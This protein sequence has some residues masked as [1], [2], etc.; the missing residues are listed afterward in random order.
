M[1]ILEFYC[2]QNHRIYQFLARTQAQAQLTPLCPDNP[3]Y[4]LQRRPSAFAIVG[5]AKESEEQDGRD[6]FAHL[7]EWALDSLMQDMESQFGDEDQADPDPRQLG[8]F[9]GRLT[10]MMGDKAPPHL[11]EIVRRLQAGEDPEKIEE[12]FGG[13][14]AGD[15]S[16]NE[17]F[18]E[19]KT[20][21]RA[22]R[23]P[24]RDPKL[25]DLREHLPPEANT[26]P[27]S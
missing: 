2:P 22:H 5:K 20:L 25:Y 17:L 15:E 1:P 10:S 19:V 16:V 26:A 18:S 9:M 12:Q 13:P 23:A 24:Q 6:P 4:Q 11:R 21:L 3:A 7:D 14:D 8:H 27:G